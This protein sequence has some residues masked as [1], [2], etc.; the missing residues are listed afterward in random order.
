MTGR[1]RWP[2]WTFVG[3]LASAHF[4]LHV[5]FGLG[6]NTAPDLLAPAVLLGARQ[7]SGAG[8]AALGVALGLLQDALSLTAFGASAVALGAL[9]YLGA[10]A[11]DLFLVDSLVF[12]GLYLFAGTWA[13]DLLYTLL[14][15]PPGRSSVLGWLV[16]GAPLAALYAAASGVAAVVAFRAVTG[17][18]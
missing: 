7:A 6:R 2:F 12:L 17:E 11:R 9:G 13:H 3:V 16:L 18:R 10:R 1:R 4:V 8:A 5:A 15:G 14:A